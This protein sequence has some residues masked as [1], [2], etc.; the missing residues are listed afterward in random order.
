MDVVLNIKIC[1]SLFCQCRYLCHVKVAELIC[2]PFR[3]I[4]ISILVFCCSLPPPSLLSPSPGV[5]SETSCLPTQGSWKPNACETVSPTWQTRRCHRPA[6]GFEA[7]KRPTC[8]RFGSNAMRQSKMNNDRK[9]TVTVALRGLQAF[10]SEVCERRQIQK[11]PSLHCLNEAES[12][13]KG[14]SRL[15]SVCNKIH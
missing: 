15:C 14:I 10:V 2:S 12:N 5:W 8:S 4:I 13:I 3:F 11:R 9:L 7:V 6:R 1:F